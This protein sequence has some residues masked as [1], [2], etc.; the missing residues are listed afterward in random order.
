MFQQYTNMFQHSEP[1]RS[2]D[3]SGD[4]SDGDEHKRHKKSRGGTPLV[5]AC[6]EGRLDDVKTFVNAG[7]D[8]NQEGK[9]SDDEECTPLMAAAE[10]EHFHIVKYLIEQGADPNIT[11]SDG[12]NALHWAAGYNKKDTK[13]IEL[14]LTKMPL[15]S[16]NQELWDGDTPLDRAYDN[17]SPI[18]QAIIKLMRSKGALR[19][20]EVDLVQTQGYAAVYPKLSVEELKAKYEQEFGDDDIAETHA[21]EKGRLEDVKKLITEENVNEED[22]FAG[23]SRTPLMAAVEK[24]QFEIVKYLIQIGADANVLNQNDENALHLAAQKDTT[25]DIVQ[26]LLGCM[27]LESI[28][29][30]DNTEGYTPLKCCEEYNDSDARTTIIMLIQSKIYELTPGAVLGHCYTLEEFR[31]IKMPDQQ[32]IMNE[33]RQEDLNDLTAKKIYPVKIQLW[34]KEWEYYRK[35]AGALYV[36]SAQDLKKWLNT[37]RPNY[38]TD[39]DDSPGTRQQVYGVQFLTQEEINDQETIL[40]TMDQGTPDQT[41]QELKQM[42]KT[43]EKNQKTI[44]EAIQ[45]QKNHVVI[46]AMEQGQRDFK[47]KCEQK[48]KQIK[49]T[50]KNSETI[51]KIENELSLIKSDN[52]L[53]KSDDEEDDSSEEDDDMNVNDLMH[54]INL[55]F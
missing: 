35:E 26:V 2:R 10:N 20:Q 31:K 44:S 23:Q 19:A 49:K 55:R 41:L 7:M 32:L 18:H 34:S 42:L 29:Q 36:Y 43:L 9:D 33:N 54:N 27:T 14:L 5:V 39:H 4:D 12:Y 50:N 52:K 21:C 28:T 48:L 6:E 3:D 17:H 53:D 47:E 1:K 30:K 8:V 16:I 40:Q 11:D 37:Y 15:T 45:E 25:G 22:R 51:N 24:Q 38:A 13:L 46:E